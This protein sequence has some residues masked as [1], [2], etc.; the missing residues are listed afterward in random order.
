MRAAPASRSLESTGEITESAYPEQVARLLFLTHAPALAEV[1]P[2][3]DLLPHHTTLAAPVSES[4]LDEGPYDAVLL[5]ATGD[6]RAA[7]ATTRLLRTA[8]PLTPAGQ[9]C[10]VLAIVTEAGLP[11][12]AAGWPIQDFVL[13]D[14]SP[15]E[16]DIRIRLVAQRSEDVP[17]TRPAQGERLLTAG[18]LSIDDESWTA[19]LRGTPLD[20]TFKEFELLR[21]LA[22]HPGRVFTREA[23]LDDVW[24]SGYYGGIR[25]VDVHI[26]RLRAKL[27]PEHDAMITTVRNVGYRF[28]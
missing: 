24:G 16:L 19:R 7:R 11:A 20:L 10:P 27:G 14:A 15:G 8:G 25:T 4:L 28:A 6:L 9:S 22:S 23:L 2:G 12:L 1:L 21:H 13:R 26:R 5:D 3:L 18:D 17:A